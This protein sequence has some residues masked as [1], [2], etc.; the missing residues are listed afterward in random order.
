MERLRGT[1]GL[2]RPLLRVAER[3]D[4]RE[5]PQPRPDASRAFSRPRVEGGGG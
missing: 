5:A 2:S 4:T 3:P 1:W